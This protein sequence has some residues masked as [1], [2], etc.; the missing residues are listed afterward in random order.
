MNT[1]QNLFRKWASIEQYSNVVKQIRQWAKYHGKPLPTITY[2]GTV[3]LHGTN[4]CIVLNREDDGSISVNAQS[5][6]RMLTIESDNAGFCLW[7]NH[8]A[9]KFREYFQGW[10]DTSKTMYIYGEWCGGSI[11]KGVALNQ[12]EKHF[13]MFSM[14]VVHDAGEDWFDGI[15]F[16]HHCRNAGMKDVTAIA[17]V[18]EPLYIT[19]DFNDPGAIQAFLYEETM[20]V[21]QECPYAKAFGVSGIGEGLVWKP[22][23]HVEG[24]PTIMF[25]TKGEKHSASK[26]KVVRE[27]TSAEI[28]ARESVEE[29]VQ[30]FVTENRLNQGFDKLTE[31][32]L[33]HEIK[34]L[35]AY[36]K[37]VQG[38]VMREGND[39]IV[40]SMLDPKAINKRIPEIARKFF[41][42][43]LNAG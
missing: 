26:V 37:W 8:H 35:G 22:I 21:E 23:T 30:H 16:I 31:M 3:K 32:G 38:D 29:F 42:D 13:A 36:I 2:E 1:A 41:I 4:A 40:A 34:N 7:V 10:I 27:I 6:E 15:T 11:Q 43:K 17:D 19:V 14:L 25:K 24:L 18:V 33:S 20:K 12:L 28:E 9:D 39:V 5:R